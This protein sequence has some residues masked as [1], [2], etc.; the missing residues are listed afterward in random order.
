MSDQQGHDRFSSVAA[1]LI[2]WLGLALAASAAGSL[3]NARPQMI[4]MIVALLTVITLVVCW[5]LPAAQH[6]AI[7]LDVRYILGF[8]L[9]RFVA[10]LFF[11]ID[12]SN[13]RLAAAFAYPAAIGDIMVAIFALLLIGTVAGPSGRLL[14]VIWNAAGLFDILF[15]VSNALWVGL[16]DW[17]GMVPLRELPLSLLPTFVVPVIIAS[18][19][20]IFVRLA[21]R[22]N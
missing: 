6:A 11:L 2:I 7:S 14:L 1:A 15:V 4:P 22:R 19:I 9:V 8:H 17:A 12:A 18:H 3:R 21:R 13:G 5:R 16:R 10:A 20:V